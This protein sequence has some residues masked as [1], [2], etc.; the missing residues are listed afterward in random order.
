MVQVLQYTTTVR[1]KE[2]RHLTIPNKSN[3]EW[4][5]RP[6]IDGEYWSGPEILSIGPTQARHYELTYHP[7]TMTTD[8][9]KHQGSIFFPLPDG[10][11]LLYNLQGTAEPPKH[12]GAITQVRVAY[13]TVQY[14]LRIAIF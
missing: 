3:S 8:M 6:I 9:Q 10:T 4:L 11:G 1:S 5:L 12:A 14:G 7:V 13:R 2:I